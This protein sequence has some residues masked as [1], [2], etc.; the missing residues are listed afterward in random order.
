MSS[1]SELAGRMILARLIL[2]YFSASTSLHGLVEVN[3]EEPVGL[4]RRFDAI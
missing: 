4:E 1:S 3:N 2:G